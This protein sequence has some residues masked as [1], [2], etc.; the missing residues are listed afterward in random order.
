MSILCRQV[1]LTNQERSS[2]IRQD[3]SQ[4]KS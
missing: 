4:S 3:E 2:M 1:T